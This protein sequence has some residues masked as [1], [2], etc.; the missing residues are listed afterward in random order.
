MSFLHSSFRNNNIYM[1]FLHSIIHNNETQFFNKLSIFC[2]FQPNYS[3]FRRFGG[4][5]KDDKSLVSENECRRHLVSSRW[6]RSVPT[7]RRRER[8]RFPIVP[9]QGSRSMAE[10]RY[11]KVVQPWL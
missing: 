4:N 6:R 10:Q 3:W 9:K 1:S 5:N 2:K 11:L 7:R 8:Q